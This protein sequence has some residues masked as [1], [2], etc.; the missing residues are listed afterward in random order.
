M[1]VVHLGSRVKFEFCPEPRS[2]EKVDLPAEE[3]EDLDMEDEDWEVEDKYITVPING[4]AK[5]KWRL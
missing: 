1:L 4:T 2:L 5:F 3:V